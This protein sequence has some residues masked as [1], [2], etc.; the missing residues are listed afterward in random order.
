LEP[1]SL[2]HCFSNAF[3]SFVAIRSAAIPWTCFIVFQ[4]SDEVTD[5]EADSFWSPLLC[6]CCWYLN[7]PASLYNTELIQFPTYHACFWSDACFHCLH[8]TRLNNI[9]NDFVNTVSVHLIFPQVPMV[10]C[11]SDSACYAD[12]KLYF[13]VSEICHLMFWWICLFAKI[14]SAM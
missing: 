9:V 3:L 11:L 8:K 12:F 4:Y 13:I 14:L 1:G 2:P 7:V 5:F 10:K 6:S